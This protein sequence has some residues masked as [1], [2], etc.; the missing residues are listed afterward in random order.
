[1]KKICN[2]AN[3]LE[4]LLKSSAPSS[5]EMA[6]SE[7]F[8]NYL[9]SKAE[10]I[11]KDNI[12]NTIAI[13]N[14]DGIY[15]ILLTAHIDEIGFQ[16]TDICNDGL[17]R[18][19]KI[20]GINTAYLNGHTV[21][22]LT[23][24]SIVKGTLVC[25]IDGENNTV[26]NI[27]A[28]YIDINA[29]NGEEAKKIIGIGDYVTF[30]PSFTSSNN[31][32]TSKSLDNRIGVFIISQIFSKLSGHLKNIQLMAAATTQEE[33]GLRGMALVAQET[34]PDICINFDV[35]DALQ[36]GKEC[37]PEINK[38]VVFYKNADSNPSLK[39]FIINCAKE[40]DIPYQI[41]LGRNITGGTDCS[42]IQLFSPKTAVTELAIPCKYIHSHNEKCGTHDVKDAIDITCIVISVLD[43]ALSNGKQLIFSY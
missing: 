12:G 17:L 43:T 4:L 39:E 33:I 32:I 30:S 27:D 9:R 28:I 8:R 42:R 10:H 18:I 35:T 26:P 23:D 38:G 37:L 11:I 36:I 1:M 13:T 2:D 5:Y 31:V 15:K 19:R 16:I 40:N 7:V 6:A 41:S 3:Y 20:G 22:I 14:S 21:N 24:H 34:S 25:K 29:S